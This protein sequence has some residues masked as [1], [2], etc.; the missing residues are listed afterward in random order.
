MNK[1][2]SANEPGKQSG[3]PQRRVRSTAMLAEARRREKRRKN[4][5][6][7][8]IGAVV[9]L[10]VLGGTVALLSGQDDAPQAAPPNVTATGG[11]VVGDPAAPVTVS[12]VEDYG[13]PHCKAFASQ[14][15]SLLASYAAGSEVKVEYRGIAFLDRAFRAEY[16]S[17]ALNAST[18]VAATSDAGTW[19]GFHDALFAQQPAEGTEGIDPDTL[20][21]IAS[22]AGATGSE[23]Q[24]CII[25][26]TYRDWGKSITDATMGRDGVEGTPT[27]FVNGVLV[28]SSVAAIEAAVDEALL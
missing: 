13:C 6:R 5:I 9:V 23:T 10:A 14:A 18:C 22:A 3:M 25:D 21:A 11:I 19:K 16:S 8:A 4:L 20:A 28:E 1:P 17:R 26:G 27:V 7:S 24:K 12:I 2:S 15:S